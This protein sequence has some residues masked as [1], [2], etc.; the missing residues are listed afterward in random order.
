MW[1]YFS[2]HKLIRIMLVCAT[3]NIQKQQMVVYCL[4]AK[5]EL[6]YLV[7]YACVWLDCCIPC[8]V[9]LVL[10]GE[11]CVV[12][13]CPHWI[14]PVSEGYCIITCAS[15]FISSCCDVCPMMTNHKI[16]EKL[17][18]DWDSITGVAQTRSWRAGVLQSLNTPE[19]ANQALTC[20]LENLPAGVWGKVRSKLCRTPALQ[21]RVWASLL[22]NLT[23]VLLT[24]ISI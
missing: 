5:C 6:W 12:C 7:T 2:A 9:P 16:N 18:I 24:H 11:I 17:D 21:D 4:C 1:N 19:A 15:E 23:S 13:L 10:Q 14:I 8:R 3:K 20:I 22:Y